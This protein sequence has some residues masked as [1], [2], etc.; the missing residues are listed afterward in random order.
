MRNYICTGRALMLAALLP[1]GACDILEVESAGRIADD[2]LNNVSA[3]EGM[4]VGQ[5]REFELA[6][7]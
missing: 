3:L 4:V 5:E 2:D 6:I 7:E 1:M